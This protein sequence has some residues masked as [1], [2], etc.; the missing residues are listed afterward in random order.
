MK[1]WQKLVVWSALLL[2]EGAILAG[3]LYLPSCRLS[4]H[5]VLISFV[6]LLS[7]GVGAI[8]GLAHLHYFGAAALWALP[9][10]IVSGLY[11]HANLTTRILAEQSGLAIAC[12]APPWQV[13]LAGLVGLACAHGVMISLRD[14]LS[15]RGLLWHVAAFFVWIAMHTLI[16]PL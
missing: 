5:V 8:A 13:M 14:L 4:E 16:A 7:A 3:L 10:L 1:L 12:A 9:A 6:F 11:A 2:A 15:P